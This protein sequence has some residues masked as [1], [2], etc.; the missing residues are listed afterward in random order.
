MGGIKF[1]NA[2]LSDYEIR[3]IYQEH[4]TGEKLSETVSVF[5]QLWKTVEL[6]RE[7]KFITEQ[8]SFLNDSSMVDHAPS[9]YSLLHWNSRKTIHKKGQ[10]HKNNTQKRKKRRQ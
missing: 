1:F 7:S 3:D 6:K 8:L 5:L 4:Q 2:G 9:S 10:K